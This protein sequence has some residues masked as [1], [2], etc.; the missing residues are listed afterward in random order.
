MT[1]TLINKDKEWLKIDANTGLING[2]VDNI[3]PIECEVTVKS[4][5]YKSISFQIHID[6]TNVQFYYN[7]NKFDYFVYI[8]IITPSPV[9]NK[10][11]DYYTIDSALPNGLSFN[12]R[13]GQIYGTTNEEYMNKLVITGVSELN[14]S[15][16]LSINITSII[17][18]YILFY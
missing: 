8:Y 17:Y 9:T 7:P 14:Y 1:F 5:K 11:F 6:I 10:Q 15:A 3:I 16:S 2:I 4:E 13:T 18:I 12:T